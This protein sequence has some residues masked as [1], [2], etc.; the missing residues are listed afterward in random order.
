MT[1]HRRKKTTFELIG[2]YKV[3][4]TN[5][6]AYCHQMKTTNCRNYIDLEVE[7]ENHFF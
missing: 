7:K 5:L 6:K 1:W 3:I 4:Y 2:S